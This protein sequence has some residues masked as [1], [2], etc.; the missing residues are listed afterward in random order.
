MTFAALADTHAALWDLID[1]PRLSPP[2]KAVIQ[3]A[4]VHGQK[5]GISSITLIEIVYLVEKGRVPLSAYDDL[6]QALAD[7]AHVFEEVK[8]SVRIADS[9]RR[10]SSKEI[11]D[12]P[13]R[14]IAATGLHLGV[15]VISRDS[16]IRSA[17]LRTIW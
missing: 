14:I 13:D 4:A 6:K 9:M 15:P 5:I 2:A 3:D 11:P 16:K 17:N 1:D 10:V 8:V 7:P 12:M